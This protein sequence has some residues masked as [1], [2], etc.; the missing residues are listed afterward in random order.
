MWLLGYTSSASGERARFGAAPAF[1]VSR[2]VAIRDSRNSGGS[3]SGR[4]KSRGW[5]RRYCAKTM[6]ISQGCHSARSRRRDMWCSALPGTRKR[7]P[8]DQDKKT[9]KRVER[10]A[11]RR[12]LVRASVRASAV[13]THTSPRYRHAGYTTPTTSSSSP[14]V[15]LRTSKAESGDSRA[16]IGAPSEGENLGGAEARAEV[17][18]SVGSSSG[19]TQ[20]DGS[21]EGG[22]RETV[23]GAPEFPLEE[24]QQEEAEMAKQLRKVQ[25]LVEEKRRA[26]R[27]RGDGS[28]VVC[29]RSADVNVANGGGADSKRMR[30]VRA[31]GGADEAGRASLPGR[32]SAA[33]ERRLR[34][35]LASVRSKMSDKLSH[36]NR[37]RI[38]LEKKLEEVQKQSNLTYQ[39]LLQVELNVQ[40]VL[41]ILAERRRRI[42]EN[43]AEERTEEYEFIEAMSQSMGALEDDLRAVTGLVDE[44][45]F[46]NFPIVWCGLA[47]DVRVMGSFDMWTRGV[48]LSPYSGDGSDH[49]VSG[50]NEFRG[51]LMLLPGTY[52]IKFLVDGQWRLAQVRPLQIRTQCTDSQIIALSMCHAFV[53]FS[54]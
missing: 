31:G 34:E 29:E 14:G 39:Q 30:R 48:H 42:H 45:R 16:P 51:E 21:R 32:P 44:N 53:F 38:V 2:S 12:T 19:Q 25:A 1:P 11:T 17:T 46:R 24:T 35:Q 6:A 9:K 43:F 4:S 27:R 13:A 26:L 40:S 50:A 23:D 15:S 54:P 3:K 22:Q 18:E 47:Q 8:L 36:A 7:R 28:D 49:F 41:Q 37:F 20:A 52:E 33:A 5:M 10:E